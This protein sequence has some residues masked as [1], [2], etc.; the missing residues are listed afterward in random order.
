MIDTGQESEDPGGQN[1]ADSGS[2]DSGEQVLESTKPGRR[3]SK[4]VFLHTDLVSRYLFLQSLGTGSL[5]NRISVS[6]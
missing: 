4:V 2:Q 1:L 6:L 3:I 5:S